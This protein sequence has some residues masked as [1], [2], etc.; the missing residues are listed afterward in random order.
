MLPVIPVPGTEGT[1]GVPQETRS[2]LPKLPLNPTNWEQITRST[3]PLGIL[4]H[5]PHQSSRETAA[6]SKNSRRP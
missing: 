3:A 5:N 6:T 4:A 2:D 1:R